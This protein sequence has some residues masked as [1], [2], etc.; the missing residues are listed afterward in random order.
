MSPVLLLPLLPVQPVLFPGCLPAL[1]CRLLT[2]CLLFGFP[3]RRRSCPGLLSGRTLLL[4]GNLTLP[5]LGV[6]CLGTAG[7]RFHRRS[8]AQGA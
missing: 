6:L 1:L 3:S 8:G 7:R 5:P 2:A 4:P